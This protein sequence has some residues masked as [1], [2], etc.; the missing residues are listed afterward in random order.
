MT[1]ITL[2]CTEPCLQELQSGLQSMGILKAN[3]EL[4]TAYLF[5]GVPPGKAAPQMP[6]AAALSAAQLQVIDINKRLKK[7]EPE[8]SEAGECSEL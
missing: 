2:Q 5:K 4:L 1:A 8:L 3:A 7:M 6:R